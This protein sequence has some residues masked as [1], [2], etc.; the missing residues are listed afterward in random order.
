M[1]KFITLLLAV[2]IMTGSVAMTANA[3]K[4]ENEIAPYYVVLTSKSAQLVKQGSELGS[5]RAH[6]KTDGDYKINVTMQAQRNDGGNWTSVATWYAEGTG[7]VSL[8]KP[9]YFA[10]DEEYRVYA[11]A[12]IY[13]ANGNQ[14][15]KVTASSY[16]VSF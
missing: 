5:C 4:I 13:D 11:V 12:T 15:E 8:S 16:S 14:I 6:F 10:P 3:A 1:K 7:Y 2:L 9:R